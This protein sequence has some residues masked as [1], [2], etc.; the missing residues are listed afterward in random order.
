VSQLQ[1]AHQTIGRQQITSCSLTTDV[2][3]ALGLP[4]N[5]DVQQRHALA[6][7]ESALSEAHAE[8]SALMARNATLAV[9]NDI[10]LDENMALKA[11]VEK[12]EADLYR[13]YEVLEEK[14]ASHQA[15]LGH[16]DILRGEVTKNKTNIDALVAEIEEWREHSEGLA[17]EKYKLELAVDEYAQTGEEVAKAYLDRIFELEHQLADAHRVIDASI[18]EHARGLCASPAWK[19]DDDSDLPSPPVSEAN[20]L[21]ED[22]PLVLDTPVQGPCQLQAM[23][24]L[25]RELATFS[26]EDALDVDNGGETSVYLSNSYHPDRSSRLSSTPTPEGLVLQSWTPFLV[27]DRLAPV[28]LSHRRI[29]PNA[30]GTPQIVIS[31]PNCSYVVILDEWA[32]ED[33]EDDEEVDV[34]ELPVWRNLQ[35]TFYDDLIAHLKVPEARHSIWEPRDGTA[36]SDG[37]ISISDVSCAAGTLR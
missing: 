30:E 7:L 32:Y 18:A 10:L 17:D 28:P 2:K 23:A 37:S 14:D 33:D 1:D 27:K 16:V 13:A 6:A 8:S 19:S 29:V 12:Y 31:S 15:E 21:F 9:E 36:E 26:I 20:T 4:T 24:D 22:E 5:S 25:E 35:A 3:I 11:N 34:D